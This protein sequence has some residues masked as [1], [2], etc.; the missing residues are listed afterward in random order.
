MVA[1]IT[2]TLG[3]TPDRFWRLLSKPE[4]LQYV[5]A[6]ILAFRPIDQSGIDSEWRV[7]KLYRLSLYLFAILPLGRHDIVLRVLDREAN[8]IFSTEYGSIAKVWN[9]IIEFQPLTESQITYTDTI[10]IQAGLLTAGV[11]IFAHCFYRHRQ[12]RWK[13]L[14]KRKREDGGEF[15]HA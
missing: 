10:D 8:R 5:S 14:L 6:P 4:S 13:K 15:L 11:W 2:T 12:R 3:S 1:T 9:H 7:G